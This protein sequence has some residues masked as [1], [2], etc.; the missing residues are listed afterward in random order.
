MI[1]KR[2]IW[3][4]EEEEL[5]KKLIIDKK[6]TVK[7]LE[8]IFSTLKSNI[9]SKLKRL[10]LSFTDYSLIKNKNY[11]IKDD[12]ITD[13][14]NGLNCY[15][16]AKKYNTTNTSV[17]KILK[18]NNIKIIPYHL[19]SAKKYDFNEN[20]FD[21]IDTKEKAYWLGLIYADGNISKDSLRISLKI[22]DIDILKQF[23]DCIEYTGDI[24]ISRKKDNIIYGKKCNFEDTATINIYSKH[25]FNTIQK[26]GVVPNKTHLLTFP[27]FLKK[28]LIK[29]FMLGYFDGDGGV[30]LTKKTGEINISII[31]TEAFILEYQNILIK[32]LGFKKTKLYERYPE[33]NTNTRSF[34]YGGNKQLSK[35]IKWLYKDEPIFLSRKYNK[36]INNVKSPIKK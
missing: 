17:A 2:K 12:I 11:F 36:L 1:K 16:I 15:Q 19:K 31:G 18:L 13:Y 25:I 29:S 35:F 20:Y 27:S 34:N 32:E 33:R 24:K 23:K 14:K 7:Q 22:S 10:N 26:W 30:S 9:Y 4:K 8:S 21:L 3:T 5:L 28:E 6:T